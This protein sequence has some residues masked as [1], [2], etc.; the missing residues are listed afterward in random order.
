MSDEH[1]NSCV[2]Y[3]FHLARAT[4]ARKHED[5]FLS[6]ISSKNDKLFF[7]HS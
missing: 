2:Q 6:E 4:H 1:L 5:N 7:L 3:S